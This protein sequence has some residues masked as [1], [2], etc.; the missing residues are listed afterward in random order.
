MSAKQ[1]TGDDLDVEQHRAPDG[2]DPLMST[3][4]PGSGGAAR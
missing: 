4:R 1:D 2:R 3:P